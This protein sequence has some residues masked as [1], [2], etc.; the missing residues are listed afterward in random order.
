MLETCPQRNKNAHINYEALGA[1]KVTK[2]ERGSHYV[3]RNFIPASIWRELFIYLL[4]M[5]FYIYIERERYLGGVI[6]IGQ[7]G[8]NMCVPNLENVMDLVPVAPHGLIFGQNEEHRLREAC[9]T[10]PGPVFGP[11]REPK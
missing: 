4:F 10:S 11:S 6:E 2:L 1:P 9:L 3:Q 7:F 5:L 8:H